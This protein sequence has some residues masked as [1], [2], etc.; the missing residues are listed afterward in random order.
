MA[1]PERLSTLGSTPWSRSRSRTGSAS[2]AVPIAV[3][4]Q[5]VRLQSWL[6]AAA[7]ELYHATDASVDDEGRKRAVPGR[8]ADVQT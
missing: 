2:G 4:P 7:G 5:I 6:Q 8:L 1:R 3:A